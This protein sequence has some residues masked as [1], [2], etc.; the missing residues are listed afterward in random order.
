M[1]SIK[2]SV[3][4]KSYTKI[5]SSAT[6]AMLANL[7]STLQDAKSDIE[8]YQN[9]ILALQLSLAD[10][11]KAFNSATYTIKVSNSISAVK[12]IKTTSSVS[13]ITTI[14]KIKIVIVKKFVSDTSYDNSDID[15]DN[16][17]VIPEPKVRIIRLPQPKLES[18]PPKMIEFKI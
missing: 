13:V 7:N 16:K 17:I 10:L 12:K 6:D 8:K 14:K 3:K 18:L 5:D 11:T 15:I 9:M 1:Q 4:S 2:A